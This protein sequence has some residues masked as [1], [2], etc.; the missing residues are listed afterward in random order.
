M[1]CAVRHSLLHS[2]RRA[3]RRL[4]AGVLLVIGLASCGGSDSVQ[5]LDQACPATDAADLIAVSQERANLLLGY[6]EAGAAECAGELGWIFRVGM[7]DGEAF[8]LTMDYST[9]R[10]TVT[11]EDDLVTAVTVG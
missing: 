6:S 1:R 7:R 11:V 4:V 9:Q 3:V 2:V 5:P 10:I 8:A